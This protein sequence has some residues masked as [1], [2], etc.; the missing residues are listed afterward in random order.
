[1]QQSI[2]QQKPENNNKVKKIKK[3]NHIFVHCGWERSFCRSLW[4]ISS[5]FLKKFLQLLDNLSGCLIGAPEKFQVSSMEFEPVT[6]LLGSN[7]DEDISNFSGAHMREG[8]NGGVPLTVD[9]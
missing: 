8:L 5:W 7:P 4:V 3:K 9:G 6:V 1:M 2:Q